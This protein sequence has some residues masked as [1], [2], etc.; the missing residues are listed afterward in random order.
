MLRTV[1]RRSA[2]VT[3]IIMAAL[4]APSRAGDT[5]PIQAR[6]AFTV[7]G[8]DMDP[9]TG[10]M[11]FFADVSGNSSHLGRFTGT[12]TETL[13]AP[14]YVSFIVEATQVAADGDELF[15]TYEGEFID[16]DGDSVGTF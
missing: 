10:D 12:A 2:T 9:T 16:A 11:I 15:L 13:F 14:D 7:V 8:E 1:S 3:L 4:A 6:G 5:V